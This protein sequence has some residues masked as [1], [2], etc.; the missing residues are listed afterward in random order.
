MRRVLFPWTV[1]AMLLCMAMA[2]EAIEPY[3]EHRE[4]L[5]LSEQQISELESVL[6]AFKKA[7]IRAEANLRIA[8]VEL[9]ELLRADKVDLPE[10][11]SKLE[12]MAKL[13]AELKFLHIK[14]NEDAKKILTEEQRRKFETLKRPKW[15]I[16]ERLERRI[17]E[18]IEPKMREMRERQREMLERLE[19]R[20]MEELRRKDIELKRIL[21][22][23]RRK[24]GRTEG[25]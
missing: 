22:E 11:K 17:Q 4:E 13:R 8:E 14:A 1:T 20:M 15:E 18:D 10:V 12:H 7:Q 9:E 21:E 2:V 25:E 5:S 19:T 24:E 6:S 23:L 16:K 3:L